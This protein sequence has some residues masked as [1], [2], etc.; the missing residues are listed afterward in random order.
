VGVK[1][2]SVEH[3]ARAIGMGGAYTSISA[4]PFSAAYNPAAVRGITKL[5]GSFGYNSY[6]GN[7]R[8]E[9]GYVAFEKRGVTFSAGVQFAAVDDM[10]KRTIAS[11]DYLP[12]DAHDVSFKIGVAFELEKNYYLGF[13][14]GWINEKI[15]HYSD[16]AFNF[17]IGLLV[18]AYPGLNVGVAILN[19]GSTLRLREESYDLPTSYRAGI[20]YTYKT[21]TGAVDVV[22]LDG[23]L[24]THLGAE[25]NHKDMFYIRS[26]YR[27]GYDSKDI[28]AG[29]GFSKR[30]FR[31]DYA[32]LPFDGS[33]GSTH[34]FNLTFHL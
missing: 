16:F 8:I 12:F 11:D 20:S 6:W 14:I 23:D 25:Y 17:D 19:Y 24:Y 30:N 32:F 22:R 4:D 15:D 26:G 21:L 28:S 29:V 3:G 33:L 34:I 18:H 1:M 9:D 7:S 13:A 31:I 2:L 10:E 5:S 27:I